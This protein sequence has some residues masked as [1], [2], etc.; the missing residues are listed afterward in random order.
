MRTKNNSAVFT[1]ADEPDVNVCT[2]DVAKA[3]VKK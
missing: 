3:E 1:A 2:E